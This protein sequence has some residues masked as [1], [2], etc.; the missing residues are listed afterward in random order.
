MGTDKQKKQ[1][2]KLK[3][4]KYRIY[5]ILNFVE[6]KLVYVDLDMEKVVFEFD[7]EGYDKEN[8]G[9]VSFIVVLV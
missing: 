3:P 6:R 7:L 5:G 9:I 8:F 1:L 4:R 2:D